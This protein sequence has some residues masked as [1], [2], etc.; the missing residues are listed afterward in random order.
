[1]DE[2]VA[3]VVSP[4]VEAWHPRLD[5][6]RL[7]LATPG[8]RRDFKAM[9]ADSDTRILFDWLTNTFVA[10][11]RSDQ[12]LLERLR[13]TSFTLDDLGRNDRIAVSRLTP[14]GVVLAETEAYRVHNYDRVP[15]EINSHCNFRC[16]FCPVATDPLA[17]RVM[18]LDL[19][20]IV[21]DRVRGA[22]I[23][24]I[25]LNHYGEPS[26]DKHLVAR[27]DLAKES[28]LHVDLFTNASGLDRPRLEA[29]AAIGNLSVIVNLPSIDPGA[30]RRITGSK[31]LDRVLDN[32][33]VAAELGMDVRVTVNAPAGLSRWQRTMLRRNIRRQTGIKAALAVV[34]S[35]A[36]FMKDQDYAPPVR[37]EGRLNGCYRQLTKIV[38]NVEAKA[39]M[40]CQ[41]YHQEYVL[42]DLRTSSFDDIARSDRAAQI[43]RWIFG[44]EDP[45]DE[46]ICRR[47]EE[48][49]TR[50]QGDNTL[51]LGGAFRLGET[52]SSVTVRSALTP[53]VGPKAARKLEAGT[54]IEPT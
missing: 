4:Y 23:K 3:L 14:A 39:F 26:L 47:C 15:I 41:D 45:P 31:L 54:G 21:L 37:H 34:E 7:M 18:P 49:R 10:V 40:C 5:D 2:S 16:R 20:G 11:N 51:S 35:R 13:D 12:A 44:A 24:G 9:R 36:G 6:L 28:G 17:K 27:V 52:L 8:D 32:L 22:G 29:L 48:T 30:F 38:V 53:P 25:A 46:F 33:R 19:Y 43:R 42:G 1:M 50:E